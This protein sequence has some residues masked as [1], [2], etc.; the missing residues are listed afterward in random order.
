MK[1]KARKPAQAF[2]DPATLPDEYA[3]RVVGDCLAPAIKEGDAVVVDKRLPY[4][5]GD[6][7]V[8]YM[9]PEL[10]QP[11]RDGHLRQAAGDERRA[12]RQVSVAGAS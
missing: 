9:R 6:L 10:V 1:S 5:A 7:V 8:I 3:M 12:L 4:K 2:L 11:R